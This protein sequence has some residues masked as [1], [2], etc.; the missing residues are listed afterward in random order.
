MAT[1]AVVLVVTL[2]TFFIPESPRWLLCNR[3]TA[4]LRDTVDQISRWNKRPLSAKTRE[5]FKNMGNSCAGCEA[6]GLVSCS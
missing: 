2:T 4:Q 1:A 6:W 5:R 3:K